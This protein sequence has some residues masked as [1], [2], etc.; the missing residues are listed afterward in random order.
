MALNSLTEQFDQEYL[1]LVRREGGLFQESF[2]AYYQFLAQSDAKIKGQ[3]I[4]SHFHPYVLSRQEAEKIGHLGE[5]MARL[6][7]KAGRL[8]F[9]EEEVRRLYNF[10][11]RLKQALEVDPGYE[12]LVPIARY[13]AFYNSQDGSLMFCEFNADG[14]SGMNET[15]T[16][17]EA[18]LATPV[19]QKLQSHFHLESFDLRGS[20]LHTLLKNFQEGQKGAEKPR[21]AIVDWHDVGTIHEFYALQKVFKAQGYDT[22]ICDPRE[23]EYRGGKLWYKDL[24]IPLVYR[25]VV[26]MELLE[27][28]GEVQDFIRAYEEGAF[29]MVGSLRTELAHSKLAFC[30]FSDPAFKKFFTPEEQEFLAAHI[31]WTRKLTSDPELLEEAKANKDKLVLKPFN[32]YSGQGVM[33]GSQCSEAQ[34]Q[35][36][37]RKYADSNYLLQEKIEIPQKIFLTAP[38]KPES[39]KINLGIFLYNE[40]FAGLY[41]RVSQDD[42]ISLARGGAVV[43]TLVGK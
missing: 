30:L 43:P 41:T 17:E 40:K 21:I 12:T 37:L 42:I 15:N 26:T 25:R 28:W 33:V 24:A 36:S 8:W 38:D 23:L 27:R 9:E 10:D 19:G 14:S 16:A 5:T 39:L 13:D 35:E 1:G 31:P 32:S 3:V 11:P 18:F 22:V 20:L 2:E 29:T 4:K 7:A 34:W 6:I